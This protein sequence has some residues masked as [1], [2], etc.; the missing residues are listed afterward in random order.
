M[1]V[2]TGDKRKCGQYYAL[3]RT[4]LINENIG[5]LKTI[6]IKNEHNCK[7]DRVAYDNRNPFLIPIK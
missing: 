4:F 7:R 3:F 6:I 2:L 5:Q 1:A